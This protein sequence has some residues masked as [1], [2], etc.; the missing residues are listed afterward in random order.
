MSFTHLDLKFDILTSE[1]SVLQL[2]PQLFLNFEVGRGDL[3]VAQYAGGTTN[4]VSKRYSI[5]TIF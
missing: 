5:S 1:D 2:A 3:K 4:S